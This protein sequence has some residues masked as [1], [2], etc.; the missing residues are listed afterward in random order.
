VVPVRQ[1]FVREKMTMSVPLRGMI[2][3]VMLTLWLMT[4]SHFS[5]AASSAQSVALSSAAGPASREYLQY[6]YCW[7]YRHCRFTCRCGALQR[8]RGVYRM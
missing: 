2:H 7:C 5:H 1:H 3:C 8:A 4:F 6:M